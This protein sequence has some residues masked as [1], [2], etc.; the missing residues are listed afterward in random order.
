M[1][2]NAN[3]SRIMKFRNPR[4]AKMF[5]DNHG[6]I[7]KG[8]VKESTTSASSSYTNGLLPSDAMISNSIWSASSRKVPVTNEYSCALASLEMPLH[9][10]DGRPSAINS[11][12]GAL[13]SSSLAIKMYSATRVFSFF[14][15]GLGDGYFIRV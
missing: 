3:Y 2:G 10:N 8:W 13:T 4:A 15:R 1:S 12:L 5:A 11:S 7:Y 9:G 14:L 6:G